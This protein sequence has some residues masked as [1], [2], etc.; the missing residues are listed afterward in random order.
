MARI[1]RPVELMLTVIVPGEGRQKTA[2]FHARPVHITPKRLPL[3]RQLVAPDAWA[4]SQRSKRVTWGEVKA[5]ILKSLA[6]SS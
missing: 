2:V 4:R 5:S 3:L 6:D 1:Q